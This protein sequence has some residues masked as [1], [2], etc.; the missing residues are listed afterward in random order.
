MQKE[1]ISR[2][3][4]ADHRR[5]LGVSSAVKVSDDLLIK[6]KAAG[7]SQKR[8][9]AGQIEYWAT[10][11]QWAQAYPDL[12]YTQIRKL[13]QT[14]AWVQSGDI[15]ADLNRIYSAEGSK[16]PKGIVR[17]QKRSIQHEDWT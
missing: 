10:I 15:T 12:S 3:M 14:A 1:I 2:I 17:L 6:A 8:S 7:I 9:M 16:L 13:L 4:S 11:G 5:G